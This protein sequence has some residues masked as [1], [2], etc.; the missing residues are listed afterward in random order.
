MNRKLNRFL[1]ALAMF[2]LVTLPIAAQTSATKTAPAKTESHAAKAE[3][4]P[5]AA[6]KSEKLDINTATKEQLQA[7]PGIGD[8]YSQKIID[9]RPYRAKS[10]LVTKNIIPK[11][12]YDKIKNDIVAHHV[13]GEMAA[14]AGADKT[15]KAGKKGTKTTEKTPPPKK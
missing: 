6:T 12:T 3:K 1:L 9:G 13:K 15:D 8:A 7:L 5:P 11:A 14:A 4:T 2:A 10:D